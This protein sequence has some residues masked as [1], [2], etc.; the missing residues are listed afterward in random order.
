MQA[1]L[2]SALLVWAQQQPKLEEIR[3]ASPAMKPEELVMLAEPVRVIQVLDKTSLVASPWETKTELFSRRVILEGISTDNHPVDSYLG[4]GG[5]VFRVAESR[6]LGSDKVPVLRQDRTETEGWPARLQ[7]D[8]KTREEAQQRQ[9]KKIKGQVPFVLSF[10]PEKPRDPK[11][12]TTASKAKGGDPVLPRVN[13]FA[14]KDSIFIIAAMDDEPVQSLNFYIKGISP[15]G[16]FLGK[17]PLGLQGVP[18]MITERKVIR[19]VEVYYADARQA[20]SFLQKQREAGKPATEKDKEA[21]Q[22]KKD[23]MEEARKLIPDLVAQMKRSVDNH[24][25]AVREEDQAGVAMSAKAIQ[26]HLEKLRKALD[27]VCEELP[28][29]ESDRFIPQVEAAIRQG[30]EAIGKE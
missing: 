8:R 22:A 17:A 11:T 1:L 4:L 27:R 2:C 14:G 3:E 15:K 6:A 18:L 23:R 29:E 19:G 10:P 9:L 20:Q 25:K 12:T 28:K 26:G 24:Q 7:K 21:E 30:R 16:F 5:Q 13:A